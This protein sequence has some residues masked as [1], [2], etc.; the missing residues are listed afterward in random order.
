MTLVRWSKGARSEDL[1]SRLARHVTERKTQCVVWQAVPNVAFD[2]EIDR[3]LHVV[4]GRMSWPQTMRTDEQHEVLF[5]ALA[6]L[7]DGGALTASNLERQCQQLAA[8]SMKR[9]PE[10]YAVVGSISFVGQNLP[11]SRKLECGR[12]SF[13]AGLTRWDR[14]SVERE[15]DE[16]RSDGLTDFA[17][18]VVARVRA[19]NQDVAHE[20]ARREID[21]RRACWNLHENSGSWRVLASPMRAV[22]KILWGP[23]TT[24]HRAD[25]SLARD[26]CWVDRAVSTKHS[27]APKAVSKIF[28]VEQTMMRRVRTS[29]LRKFLE[30]ALVGY[31]R[32]LD[33]VD[34]EHCFL[35]LFTVFEHLTGGMNEGTNYERAMKRALACFDVSND[36][37]RFRTEELTY[38]RAFRNE[39]VHRGRA[40]ADEH[41]AV[42]LLLV[43][44]HGLLKVFLGSLVSAPSREE[45]FSALDL[46]PSR[47]GLLAQRRN[48]TKFLRLRKH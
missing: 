16:L 45:A 8:K 6:L 17:T 28:E 14:K 12:L 46:P 20:L 27:F 48:V 41:A 22:N 1:V 5:H 3:T 19:R 18:A 35:S 9:R 24:V 15:L 32:A 44:V 47:A 23:V 36:E 30:D 11:R 29:S 43:Y 42:Q 4:Q 2:L 25:G 10:Q 21:L 26:G 7:V 31:V 39:L 38:L 34:Q 40:A 13:G 33:H 37:R